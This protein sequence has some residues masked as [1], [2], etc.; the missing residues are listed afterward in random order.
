MNTMKKLIYTSIYLV[1]AA[2][3]FTTSCEDKW[4]DPEIN[5]DPDNAVDVSMD[6]L[7]AP[8]EAG[9]AY[10]L[11]GYGS[12]YSGLFTQQLSGGEGQ[13]ADND[14][15]FVQNTSPNR[16]WTRAYRG[17]LGDLK[18][19][20]EKSDDLG[21]YHYK[22]IAQV[23]TAYTIANLSDM[24]G[25]IPWSDALQGED[26]IKPTYDTHEQ[27]YTEVFRL[28]NEAITNLNQEETLY[29]V[30]DE[31]IIYGGDAAKWIRAANTL[32]AR[33]TLHQSKLNSSAYDDALA[34]L[35]AGD[36]IASNDDDMQFKFGSAA[37]EN[38]PIAQMHTDRINYLIMGE[39]YVDMM[40]ATSDPRLPMV[41]FPLDDDSFKGGAAGAIE[42]NSSLAGGSYYGVNDAPVDFVTYTERLLIEA[43][44]QLMKASPDAA[45]AATA[46]NNAVSASLAKLGVS[47]AAWEATNANETAATITLE[48]IIEAKYLALFA[49]PEVWVDWRRTGYPVL[50]IAANAAI[51]Q[52]PRRLPYP[53]D[54]AT[55]NTDNVP[56]IAPNLVLTQRLWWDVE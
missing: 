42:A 49:Q 53:D 34:I 31:D 28:L 38:A 29:P 47:D 51:N 30:G 9:M 7:L 5:N 19:V 4:I 25:D 39:N 8:S 3:L 17:W 18:V 41:A 32:R 54:E 33:Y 13:M 15:Y 37:S 11:G 27:I 12:W 50:D 21:A 6:L 46:Y 23:L 45:A 20:I 24:F 44:C 22:G 55:Y 26:N 10:I 16:L 36:V 43:E 1:F 35:N 2:L 48:K 56:V 14:R 52:I 40:L